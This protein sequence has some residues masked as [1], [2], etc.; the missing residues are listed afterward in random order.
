MRDTINKVNF[1]Q[2]LNII[3]QNSKGYNMIKVNI[4]ICNIF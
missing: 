4:T 2:K 1:M 3:G